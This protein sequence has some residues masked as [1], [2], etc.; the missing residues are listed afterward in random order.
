MVGSGVGFNRG[1][2]SPY[3]V[4]VPTHTRTLI[5]NTR[6]TGWCT[7][8]SWDICSQNQ[9][10]LGSRLCPRS[11]DT[12]SRWNDRTFRFTY[13]LLYSSL[14]HHTHRVPDMYRERQLTL[15]IIFRLGHRI[16]QE[17]IEFLKLELQYL[18]TYRRRSPGL[19]D[20]MI[21]GD[22]KSVWHTE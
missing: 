1:K 3:V 20:R 5:N 2:D 21:E 14:T 22:I 6:H 12:D 4:D 19:H 9:R 7:T 13:S 17:E 11:C 18:I 8:K 15:W 16:G 10:K